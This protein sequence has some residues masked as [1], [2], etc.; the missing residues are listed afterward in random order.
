[1]QGRRN[2]NSHSFG[3]PKI[4][5]KRDGARVVIVAWRPQNLLQHRMMTHPT[6][7]AGSELDKPETQQNHK[8]FNQRKLVQGFVSKHVSML[9]LNR[10]IV[11]FPPR[12]AVTVIN[13]F[14]DQRD[15]CGRPPDLLW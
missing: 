8:S 6:R 4:I 11:R 2:P 15:K 13:Q 5:G 12:S 9:Q 14:R 10:P 7:A 1:M 3:L